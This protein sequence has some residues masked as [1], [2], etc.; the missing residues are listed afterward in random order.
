MKVFQK[1]SNGYT[2]SIKIDKEDLF[3]SLDDDINKFT[4]LKNQYGGGILP[5]CDD[6]WETSSVYGDPETDYCTIDSI[7]Q[8][9]QGFKDLIT[10]LIEGDG[11]EL[12]N[13]VSLKKN[14]T[15]KKNAKPMLKEAIYGSYWEDSYG[16]NAQVLRIEP[17]DDTTANVLLS[18][19]TLHY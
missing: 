19:I 2:L 5:D 15:F 12:W 11:T 3:K 16:W 14:G 9:L 10:R 6:R 17:W 8:D 7:I 4:D 18:N 1:E 13:Q